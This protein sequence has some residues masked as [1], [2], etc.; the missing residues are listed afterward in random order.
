MRTSVILEQCIEVLFFVNIIQDTNMARIK[1]HQTFHSVKVSSSRSR[2]DVFVCLDEILYC[3]SCLPRVHELTS[4]TYPLSPGPGTQTTRS[5]Q[6]K[7]IID[8]NLTT[9][10]HTIS[11]TID[12]KWLQVSRSRVE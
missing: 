8:A 5:R 3:F 11:P 10:E 7:A 12:I 2:K 9:P 6:E 1:S 4:V